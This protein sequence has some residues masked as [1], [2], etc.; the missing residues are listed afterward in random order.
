MR[1]AG[2][3]V[4]SIIRALMGSRPAPPTGTAEPR[5]VGARPRGPK[6]PLRDMH[7]AYREFVSDRGHPPTHGDFANIIEVS[8]STIRNYYRRG[9]LPPKA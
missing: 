4:N 5:D 7:D 6:V 3:G 1:T 9:Y 8:V 2:P